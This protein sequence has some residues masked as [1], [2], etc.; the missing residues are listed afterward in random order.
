MV[1]MS[2][3]RGATARSVWVHPILMSRPSWG[4]CRPVR[5]LNF[6]T[7]HSKSISGWARRSLPL[8]LNSFILLNAPHVDLSPTGCAKM[9][10]QHITNELRLFQVTASARRCGG[11]YLSCTSLMLLGHMSL[12]CS[13]TM[14]LM[15]ECR[16]LMLLGHMSLFC[17][18]TTCSMNGCKE[19]LDS[20]VNLCQYPLEI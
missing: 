6:Q 18:G 19:A 15:N 9:L 13:G 10:S 3:K 2:R 4:E 7:D 17:S 11:K 1:I 12:F 20:L 14:C 16:S 5:E 8:S